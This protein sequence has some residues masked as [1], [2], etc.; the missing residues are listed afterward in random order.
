MPPH[1]S[2]PDAPPYRPPVGRVRWSRFAVVMVPALG[3]TAVV[4]VSIAGSAMAAS[5]NVSG[6]YFS[7]SFAHVSGRGFE[8]LTGAATGPDGAGHPVSS[9]A[10]R[11]MT[12]TGMCEAVTV[13]TPFGDMSLRITAGGGGRPVRAR[14][15]VVDTD[16]LTGDATFHALRVGGRPGAGP[17]GP[18]AGDALP[19]GAFAQRAGS[20]EIGHLSQRAYAT[21]AGTFDLPG[22]RLAVLR[23]HRACA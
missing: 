3:A 14:N 15:L 20:L 11:T 9:T 16:R 21:T 22:L 7:V 6:R 10:V 8:Q 2:A 12:A 4:F 19:A 23:G 13:P 18:G 17:A 5:F 1:S